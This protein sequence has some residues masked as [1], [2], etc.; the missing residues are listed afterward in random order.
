MMI[1]LENYNSINL[2]IEVK[3]EILNSSNP[4]FAKHNTNSEI[5]ENYVFLLKSYLFAKSI[6][7][8]I[9]V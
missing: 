6:S 5:I 1:T 3:I 8:L 2:F 9:Q 4:F 7:H